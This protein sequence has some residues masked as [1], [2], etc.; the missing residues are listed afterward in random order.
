MIWVEQPKKR[1]VAT[2]RAKINYTYI[3]FIDCNPKLEF[4]G[5]INVDD[6]N[7]YNP[8]LQ[9]TIFYKERISITKRSFLICYVSKKTVGNGMKQLGVGHKEPCTTGYKN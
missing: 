3:T 6:L 8:Y 2:T 4:Q 1:V 9:E 7:F 5:L